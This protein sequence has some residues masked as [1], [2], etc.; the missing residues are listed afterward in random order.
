MIRGINK[1]KIFYDNQDKNKF[2]KILKETKERYKY[3][4]YAYCLMNNHVHLLIFDLKNNISNCLKSLE[5]T[6]ALYFNKKYN[7]VGHLFQN[8]YKSKAVENE[9]YLLK[10]VQYIHKNPEKAEICLTGEYEWSSFNEYL[11]KSKIVDCN[12]ILTVFDND[13]SKFKRFHLIDTESYADELEFEFMTGFDDEKAIKIIQDEL[14][15]DDLSEIAT[16]NVKIRNNI[17]KK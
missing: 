12:F 13:I 4:I 10:L 15:I 3:E 8:R 1:E 6:Y 17:I 7:R 11:Y 5:I 16:Y 9:R 2:L 14:K